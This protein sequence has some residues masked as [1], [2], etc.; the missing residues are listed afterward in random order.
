MSSVQSKLVITDDGQVGCQ[1]PAVIKPVCILRMNQVK[2]R[3]DMLERARLE[4]ANWKNKSTILL[5]IM[6]SAGLGVN[7][8]GEICAQ[9]FFCREPQ[10]YFDTYFSPGFEFLKY[11]DGKHSKTKEFRKTIYLI[12][13]PYYECVT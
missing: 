6:W 2:Q 7:N 11:V 4:Q 3:A 8:A 1:M 5:V 13:I 12:I 10:E 9:D